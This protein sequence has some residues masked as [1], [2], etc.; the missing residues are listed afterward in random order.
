MVSRYIRI[1]ER[2]YLSTLESIY[3]EIYIREDEQVWS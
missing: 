1:Y 2:L 3:K